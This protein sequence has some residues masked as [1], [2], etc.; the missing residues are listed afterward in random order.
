MAMLHLHVY[1]MAGINF[2]GSSFILFLC[3]DWGSFVRR[4]TLKVPADM[5]KSW[6]VRLILGCNWLQLVDVQVVANGPVIQA[7]DANGELC[8]G[9]D[10]IARAAVAPPLLYPL[11]LAW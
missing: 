4:I 10:A 8:S 11:A 3:L 9:L 6:I 5:S 1:A 7:V 2:V